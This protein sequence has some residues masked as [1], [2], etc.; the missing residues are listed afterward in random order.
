[1]RRREADESSVVLTQS[2]GA[3]ERGE[4]GREPMA[5]VDIDIKL[6]VAATEVL[7]ERVPNENILVLLGS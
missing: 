5:R 2:D 3:S 1:M 6:V 7:D 4:A